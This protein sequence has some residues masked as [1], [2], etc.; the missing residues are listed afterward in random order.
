MK[1]KAKV[2][3]NETNDS[4]KTE[5]AKMNERTMKSNAKPE[6]KVERKEGKTAKK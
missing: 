6:M 4:M 3:V 1:M 2:N 5:E